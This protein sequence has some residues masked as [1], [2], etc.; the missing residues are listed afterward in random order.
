VKGL[1]G[2]AARSRPLGC[3]DVRAKHGLVIGKFYPPHAG[4]H[5]LVR[6][7][8]ARSE[9]LSVLVMGA[10][11]ESLGID[12]RVAWMREEHAGE[13][14][15]SILGVRD[16]HPV[17]YES[18]AVWRAHVELMREGARSIT[19]EPV[20]AVYTSEPYGEELGRRLGARHVLV[21][22]S[23]ESYPVSGTA[24]R[25]DLVARW[26]EL[27]PA[28]RGGLALRV[29]LVGAE[30]T[31][32]TTLAEAMCERLRL[33]RGAW[34]HVTWVSEAG[35]DVTLEKLARLGPGAE[36]ESLVWETPDFEEIALEQN[37]R[38]E[39]AARR[40][41]P[42]LLCDTD[43][44][45]TGVWHERYVGRRAPEVEA[46]ASAGTRRFYLLTH[47]DD[48]P[49]VDDGA[50]DGEHLRP[51]MTAR[52]AERLDAEGFDWAWLRGEREA[53]LERA[54]AQVDEARA[55]AHRFRDPLG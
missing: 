26:S 5:H 2:L 15:V 1:L 22:L 35:R 19:F 20:D 29:V 53:R 30:S 18:D 13:T 36:M 21:D 31:G 25:R 4:H 33:R 23:R 37:R 44:F 27:A 45:A 46:H 28:V 32:K 40:G 12:E 50:R 16:D 38:E 51:W 10:S 49:F 24:V 14:N 34:E 55:R 47:P 54:L 52:F 42:V 3:D 41:G 11:V 7:A 9:R 39:E 6:E 8:A 17:D 48:V 43:A